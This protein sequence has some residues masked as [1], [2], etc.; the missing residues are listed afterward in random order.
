MSVLKD[1]GT[2]GGI[3]FTAVLLILAALTGLLLITDRRGEDIEP[4][5][6][7]VQRRD[8]PCCSGSGSD[9]CTCREECGTPRCQAGGPDA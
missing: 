6:A 8:C 4:W 3:T 2:I 9:D 7:R 5:G 1:I